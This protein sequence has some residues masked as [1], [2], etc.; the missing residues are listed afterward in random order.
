MRRKLRTKR[1]RERY[2]LRMET[3]EPVF[4]QIKQGRGF[5]QFL[6]RG[7]EKVNR[8]W[9]LICTGHNCLSCSGTAPGSPTGA[10]QRQTQQQQVS[11]SY[12]RQVHA[13]P[14][15]IHEPAPSHA[16][17]LQLILGRAASVMRFF[18]GSNTPSPSGLSAADE[19]K[20]DHD[21]QL[22]YGEELV[23]I[24]INGGKQFA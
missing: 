24:V 5:R 19:I 18:L 15:G 12:S 9:L 20:V 7:L 14:V 10:T 13:D 16:G 2:A 21:K 23:E 17:G 3:V 4:G 11:R 22:I 1:G 6:L 8:E